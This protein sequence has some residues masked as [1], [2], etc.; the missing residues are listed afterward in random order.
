[1]LGVPGF[2]RLPVDEHLNGAHVAGEV[3]G[4]AVGGG[5]LA[6]QDRRIVPSAGEVLVP[7]PLLQVRKR[8]LQ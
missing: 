6:L 4:L 3:A 5:E 1:M 7:Q 2:G 8:Q